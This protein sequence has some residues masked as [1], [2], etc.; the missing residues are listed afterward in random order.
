MKGATARGG[1]AGQPAS[2]PEVLDA[3]IERAAAHAERIGGATHVAGVAGERALDEQLLR[4]P[5]GEVIERGG[6]ASACRLET[7]VLLGDRRAGGHED[8]AL[9]GVAQL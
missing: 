7:E 9:H 4:L 3:T 8:G 6:A 2:Q 1:A 5:E